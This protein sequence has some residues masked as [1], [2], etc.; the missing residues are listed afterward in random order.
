MLDGI[1]KLRFS[2]DIFGEGDD[3]PKNCVMEPARSVQEVEQVQRDGSDLAR[4]GWG[5]VSEVK[6]S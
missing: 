6:R 1:E 4:T 3:D 2:E 5:F